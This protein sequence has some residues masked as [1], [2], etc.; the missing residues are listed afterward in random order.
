MTRQALGVLWQT[1]Q[2][3]LLSVKGEILTKRKL[4]EKLTNFKNGVKCKSNIKEARI[5][6]RQI[7]ISARHPLTLSRKATTKCKKKIITISGK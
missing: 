5:K 6:E 3:W 1:N 7:K 2:L 4:A